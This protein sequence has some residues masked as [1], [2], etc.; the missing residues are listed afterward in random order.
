MTSV[1]CARKVSANGHSQREEKQVPFAAPLHRLHSVRRQEGISQ[2]AVSRRLGLTMSEVKFQELETTDIPL[3]ILHKWREVL[4]VP[5]AELLQEPEGSLSS[6]VKKRAEMV[7]VMKTARYIMEHTGE[8]RTKR[9]AEMLVG[10]LL[11]VM[12]ELQDVSSW[13]L[14]GPRRRRD[15]Y[16]R[17][18]EHCLPES[19][20]FEDEE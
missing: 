6:P 3:S 15:E 9:M 17:A 8:V 18:A 7:R 12:P 20:F 19:T 4:D 14:V 10:Q 16:G 13:H 5:L 1:K 2:R 11:E